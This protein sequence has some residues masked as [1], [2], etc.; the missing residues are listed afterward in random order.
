MAT[1][2][3]P[4]D[5]HTPPAGPRFYRDALAT[6]TGAKVP[7]LL[8]GG[9]ALYVRTGFARATKDLDIFMLRDDVPRGLDALTRR[10]YQ[11]EITSAY[12]LA[13]AFSGEDFIDIIF[14]S[15]NG[16]C[17]VDKRWFEHATSADF[18]G[19]AVQLCPLEEAIWQKAFVME[20]ERFDGA[21]IAHLLRACGQSVDWDRLL[22]RFGQH[23]R[24]LLAHLILFEYVFPDKRSVIPKWL[25]DGLTYR[26]RQEGNGAGEANGTCFG[27]LLSRRQY[28]IA[29][30]QWGYDDARRPPV[31]MMSREEVERWRGG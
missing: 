22:E 2:N 27:T 13:K 5:K 9:Y 23:W 31:G 10:G 17:P 8:G 25:L 3:A 20:R 15:G 4:L 19:L 14:N 28:E 12:W 18:M 29:V 24:L 21:D 1:T 26:L 30:N 7:F 16:C 11:T 6:L